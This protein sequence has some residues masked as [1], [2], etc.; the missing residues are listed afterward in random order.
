MQPMLMITSRHEGIVHIN[1]AF[2]GEVRPD[3][4]IF[5]PISA[6]GAVYI[7]F[8]PL[9]PGILSIAR[10]IALSAG[11]PVEASFE[12]MTGLS[13]IAWPFGITEIELLP[14]KIYR[15]FSE[16]R[17]VAGAGRAIRLL[18]SGAKARVEIDAAGRTYAYALP[19]GAEEPTFADSEGLI[20]LSGNAGSK[21]R[22]ALA[23]LPDASRAVAML[24]GQEIAFL[25]NRRVA[26]AES[27]GDI[28]GHIRR[29]VYALSEDGAREESTEILPNPDRVFQPATPEECAQAA[30]ECAQAGL[31]DECA[32]YFAPGSRMDE[33]ANALLSRTAACAPL[34]FSPPNGKSAIGA[35]KTVCPS[36]AIASPLYYSAE[37]VGGAWRITDLRT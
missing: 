12:E 24:S 30:A 15:D 13:A 21:T 22:Y 36:L 25:G 35:L 31:A 29:T 34:R 2:S 10:R 8:S 33:T 7:E 16:T 4:P 23:L 28:A 1:G 32:S 5:R 6:Y 18:R 11:K 27:L 14:E 19:D 20:L 17:I 3:A 37:I 26:L 9:K